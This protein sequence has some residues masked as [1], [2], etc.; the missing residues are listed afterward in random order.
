MVIKFTQSRKLPRHCFHVACARYE[1]AG[2]A[3]YADYDSDLGD[4]ALEAEQRM[5]KKQRAEKR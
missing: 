3:D 1:N 2:Y 4:D 5:R